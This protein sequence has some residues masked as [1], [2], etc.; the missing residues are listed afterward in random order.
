MKNTNGWLHQGTEVPLAMWLSILSQGRS[1]IC[2]FTRPASFEESPFSPSPILVRELLWYKMPSLLP[3]TQ[4]L[5]TIAEPSRSESQHVAIPYQLWV[6]PLFELGNHSWK[7]YMESRFRMF[8]NSISW[9]YYTF[10]CI[11]GWD[12]E[13]SQEAIPFSKGVIHIS[14]EI[15]LTSIIKRRKVT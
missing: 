3:W 12:A 5:G 7:P 15:K 11:Y 9:K 14:W 13:F 6:G 10:G 1:M 8:I 2:S 4:G